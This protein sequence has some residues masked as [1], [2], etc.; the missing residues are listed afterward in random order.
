MNKPVPVSYDKKIKKIVHEIM[1][2]KNDNPRDS[3]FRF[4]QH[5]HGEAQHISLRFPGEFVANLKTETFTIKNR[6]YRMDAAELVNPDDTLPCRSTINPEQQTT[7]ITPSKVDAMYDYK[8]QLTFKYKLP[9]LNVIVTNIGDKD[10]TIIYESHGDAYKVYVRVF[11]DEEISKRLNTL[12]YNIKTNKE[13]SEIE[14]LDFAYIM[15]LAQ[16]NKTKAYSEKVANLFSEVKKLDINLQLDM[17]YV[18][19]KLIRLHFRDDLNKTEELLTM[20]TK[21]LHPKALDDLTT[22]QKMSIELE[23][24]KT[25]L[26]NINEKC[27]TI[28]EENN[29]IKKENNNI[30]EKYNAI[31]KESAKKDEEIKKLKQQIENG[32]I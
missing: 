26:I 19:K 13:L 32:N 10:H 6:N 8:L 2:E 3:T 31:K 30:K 23:D 12:T 29:N 5:Y 15:M 4:L 24:F 17:H 27:N 11:T 1:N 7:E 20:I 9:S 22:M 25:E 28:Q 21:A 18:M 14:V 16:E